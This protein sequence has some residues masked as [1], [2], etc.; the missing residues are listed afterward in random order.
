MEKLKGLYLASDDGSGEWNEQRTSVLEEALQAHV[1]P[2]LEQELLNIRCRYSKDLLLAKCVLTK[3]AR[4]RRASISSPSACL[5]PLLA[6]PVCARMCTCRSWC[7]LARLRSVDGSVS[8][9][10]VG[11]K[12]PVVRPTSEWARS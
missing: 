8:R 12:C 1:Y 11:S 6:K 7:C 4:A 5:S 9:N 3:R 2:S 10:G